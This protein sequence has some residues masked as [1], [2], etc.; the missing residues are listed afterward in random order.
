MLIL[1]ATFESYFRPREI[2]EN[3][4]SPFEFAYAP[5]LLILCKEFFLSSF[6][7]ALEQ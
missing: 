7:F 2:F 4:S 6:K 5:I 3:I 1:Y